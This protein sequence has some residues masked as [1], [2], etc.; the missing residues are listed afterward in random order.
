MFVYVYSPNHNIIFFCRIYSDP[1]GVWQ[2]LMKNPEVNIY[3]YI[4]IYIYVHIYI[5]IYLYI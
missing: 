1:L 5:H 3:M 4:Y 2:E